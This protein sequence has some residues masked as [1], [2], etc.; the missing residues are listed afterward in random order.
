MNMADPSHRE[1]WA[2]IPWVVAGTADAS[3]RE[4]VLAHLV[5]C[6]DCRDEYRFQCQVRDGLLQGEPAVGEPS[7]ALQ[8]FWQRVDAEEAPRL[9]ANGAPVH[10][11]GSQAAAARWPQALLAVVA[12]Q[13]LALAF[14]V[15]PWG[16]R[17]PDAAYTTLS[18][19]V[20]PA[21][22]AMLRVVPA[23]DMRLG[24]WQAWLERE[25]WRVVEAGEDGR[26][27]GLAPRDPATPMPDAAALARL[28]A[29]PGLRLVEPLAR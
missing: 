7:A 5:S 4:A 6:E 10:P 11:A 26:H 1:T 24:D 8:R 15:S 17:A 12:V 3:S 29:T 16:L 25:G 22:R 9:V 21:P 2:Q 27:F 23:P 28:R 18:S 13:A 20:T 19:A 14:V